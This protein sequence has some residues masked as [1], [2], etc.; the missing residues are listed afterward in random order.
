MSTVRCGSPSPAL[1]RCGT[2]GLLFGPLATRAI[3]PRVAERISFDE[4]AEAH[5]RLEAGGLEGKVILC[6]DLQSR[7]DRMPL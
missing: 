7:R 5:C 1:I 3:Q 6:P 4:V 2:D